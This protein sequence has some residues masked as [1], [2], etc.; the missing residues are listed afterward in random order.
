VCIFLE[1]LEKQ[2]IRNL[3]VSESIRQ[4]YEEMK[5]KFRDLLGTQWCISALDFIF[6][7]PVFRNNKFTSSSGIPASTAA[8]FTRVMLDNKMLKQI[9]EPSGRRPGLYA[10]DPLMEIL[11]V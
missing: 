9:G 10:F 8:K 11:K 5:I 6:T 1:A 2:A 7:N 4:L 3:M